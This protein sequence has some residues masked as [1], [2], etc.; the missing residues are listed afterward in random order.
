MS[1][2]FTLFTPIQTLDTA[3]FRHQ[4]E[5][6]AY[7]SIYSLSTSE[8]LISIYHMGHYMSFIIIHVYVYEY[9]SFIIII[10]FI[11]ILFFLLTL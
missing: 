11:I 1:V 8:L 7:I 5:R 4:H 9:L 3:I 10:L 6:V 2:I